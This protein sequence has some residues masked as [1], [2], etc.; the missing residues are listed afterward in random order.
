MA[1]VLAAGPG[2][3]LGYRSAA[4]LWGLL[5]SCEGSVTVCVPGEGGRRGFAGVELHRSRTLTGAVV[6]HR[7]GIPVTTPARTLADLRLVVPARQWRKAV[8]QAEL[9]GFVTGIET[10]GT[11]SDLERDFLRLCRD[12]GIPAPE[13]NVKLGRWTVDFVWREHR[14]AVETD[15]YGYHRGRTPS[16]TIGPAIS[17]CAGSASPSTA[18]EEQLNEEPVVVAADLRQALGLAS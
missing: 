16:A 4:A 5:P 9:K 18:S 12:R 2:A 14:L 3:A 6:T 1:A 7:R 10:R 13:V 15:H 11:R 17:T 8:R